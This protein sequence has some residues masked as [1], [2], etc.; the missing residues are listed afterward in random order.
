[1]K[2]LIFGVNQNTVIF[3]ELKEKMYFF[4]RV[5]DQRVRFNGKQG[6]IFRIAKCLQ[7]SRRRNSI[8][9]PQR[10]VA[11]NLFFKYILK[12]KFLINKCYDKK[13]NFNKRH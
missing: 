2:L 1:M 3:Y 9:R 6:N 5:P 7:K 12:I 4:Y 10:Q 8:G 13:A 11:Y